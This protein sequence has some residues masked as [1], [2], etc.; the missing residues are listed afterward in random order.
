MEE[1]ASFEDLELS[2]AFQAFSCFLMK[3]SI[4]ILGLPI[5]KMQTFSQL[6]AAKQI[7]KRRIFSA[8]H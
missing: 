6:P 2:P 4:L 3:I 8:L 7:S 1:I 5:F